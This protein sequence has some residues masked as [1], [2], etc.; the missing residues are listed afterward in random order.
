MSCKILLVV[1]YI[2][3]QGVEVKCLECF[4]CYCP[5]AL[6]LLTCPNLG[7]WPTFNQELKENIGYIDVYNAHLESVNLNLAE[8]PVLKIVDFRGNEQMTCDALQTL[9][10][11][12][13]RQSV[14]TFLTDGLC[15]NTTTYERPMLPDYPLPCGEANNWLP[16]MILEVLFVFVSIGGFILCCLCKKRKETRITKDPNNIQTCTLE[17]LTNTTEV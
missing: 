16:I 5:A 17:H 11:S 7:I 13:Q 2:F 8:W 15:I 1:A 14:D 3:C 10:E 9:K 6:G 12:L 4:P